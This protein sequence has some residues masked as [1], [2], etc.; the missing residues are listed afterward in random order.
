MSNS[1]Y[2]VKYKNTE[3]KIQRGVVRHD[4]QEPE[5]KTLGKCLVRLM[6]ED[7]TPVLDEK[8]KEVTVLKSA[9]LLTMLGY[10]D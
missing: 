5:F 9:D 3:G 1:G 2:L 4:E 7:F 10:I 8:G 6:N